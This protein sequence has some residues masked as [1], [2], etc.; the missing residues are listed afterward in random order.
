MFHGFSGQPELVLQTLN[1]V[2]DLK[3]KLN[4]IGG[5]DCFF[6]WAPRC[7]SRAPDAAGSAPALDATAATVNSAAWY[8]KAPRLVQELRGKA[9]RNPPLVRQKLLEAAGNSNQ[10]QFLITVAQM[11]EYGDPDL[12]ALALE[13]AGDR[14]AEIQPLQERAGALQNLISTYRR[15]E[16]E[17]DSK[18]IKE[19]YV[20]AD[21]IRE[22]AAAGGVPGEATRRGRQGSP[23]DFLEAFLTGEYA[24]DNFDAAI[25]FV[26]SMDNHDAKLSALL[27][28]AQSLRNSY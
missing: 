13:V 28:I 23:A 14:I 26:R 20:L 22:E 16:G 7:G 10:V 11:A 9:T 18:L 12:S 8:E 3:A 4:E 2:P 17:V 5:L 27:Q 24:R 25:R 6:Q 15:V 19:G 1:A 21:Q